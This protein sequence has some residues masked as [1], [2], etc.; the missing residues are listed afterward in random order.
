M[1]GNWLMQDA[2][3][4]RGSIPVTVWAWVGNRI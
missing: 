1:A 2:K 3:M 4:T